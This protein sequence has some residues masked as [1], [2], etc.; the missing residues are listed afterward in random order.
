MRPSPDYFLSPAGYG[1]VIQIVSN[2]FISKV[3]TATR[4]PK[5]TDDLDEIPEGLNN[6]V[7][8]ILDIFNHAPTRLT[9]PDFTSILPEIF[10]YAHLLPGTGIGGLDVAVV[11]SVLSGRSPIN[12]GKGITNFS[13]A[14][15]E[16]VKGLLSDTTTRV[17]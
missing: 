14:I 17:A 16:K 8:L 1:E 12:N 10:V 9:P 13:G 11:S 5:G 6:S 4:R 7:Q 15:L 3:D 2:T